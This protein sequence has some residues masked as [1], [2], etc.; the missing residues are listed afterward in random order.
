MIRTVKTRNLFRWSNDY[1]QFTVPLGVVNAIRKDEA[2]QYKEY[3]NLSPED[4]FENAYMLL[5]AAKDDD[6][7]SDTL[8]DEVKYLL[9]R[10]KDK[11]F[12]KKQKEYDLQEGSVIVLFVFFHALMEDDEE[13]LD[14]AWLMREFRR[15]LGGT[16]ARTIMRRFESKEHK[17]LEKELVEFDCQNGLADTDRYRLTQK[18]KDEFLADVNLKDKTKRRDKNFIIAKDIGKKELYYHERVRD[19]VGELTRL[20]QEDNYSDVKKRLAEKGLRTGFAC[21]FSGPPGTGKTETAFQIAR[22]TGRDILLVDISETKSMWFGESEKKIKAVFDRYRSEANR[23]GPTPILLFNEAD[24]VMGKRRELGQSRSGPDQTEN[25]IQNI[26]LQEIENLNGILIATTNLTVNFD[27][28][29]ERRFI[30]KIEF[31]KPDK[32]TKKKLWQCHISS[33]SDTDA[34]FLASEFDFSGG[35]IENI[36]R[37]SSVFYILNGNPPGLSVFENYCREELLEKGGVKI[38]F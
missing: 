36:A 23:S 7:D 21:L 18:A 8:V 9:E 27:K 20:L 16:E 10:N 14:A 6:I 25:S 22:N 28:A 34:A 4:F 3:D 37:K 2:Y 5:E 12:V 35:Q 17:L 26:I 13:V 19:R 32:E 11:C 1:P 38:G 15:T 30:Y 33:L 24:A 31:G 29:F